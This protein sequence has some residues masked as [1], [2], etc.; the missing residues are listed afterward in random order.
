MG[1]AMCVNYTDLNKAYLKDSYPLS[2][3]D[4]LID[5]ASGS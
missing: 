2:S 3:I 5:V 1:S 4:G